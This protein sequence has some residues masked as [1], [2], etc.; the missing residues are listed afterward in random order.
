M[1]KSSF[2]YY[3]LFLLR[4]LANETDPTYEKDLS[5]WEEITSPPSRLC[6]EKMIWSYRANYSKYEWK[7]ITDD[8]IPKP[9]LKKETEAKSGERPPF[10]PKVEKFIG[11]YAFLQTNDGW[12]VGFNNGEF[13]ASLYW[14][15]KEGS[16]NYKIST[17]QVVSFFSTS[18]GIIA[19]EGLSHLSESQGS[20]IQI[21]KNKNR[22]EA[23]TLTELPEAPAAS[24]LFK[25]ELLLLVLHKSLA[26]YSSE[27]GLKTLAKDTDWSGL[28]PSSIALST[29]ETKAYIGMRQYIV[30]FIF[31]TGKLRYLIPNDSFL[32]KLSKD[33]EERIQKTYGD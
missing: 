23:K 10:T 26:S 11:G 3:F 14:F 13:G 32:N 7:V 30:E 9:I 18:K 27:S 20:I 1:K 21:F 16:Q 2:L 4:S 25:N 12:L 19:I 6:G 28:Y 8:P 15:N 17:H 31:N 33:D 29:D 5:K 22:W 24:V